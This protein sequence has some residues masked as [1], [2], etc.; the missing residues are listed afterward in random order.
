ML[1]LAGI[2]YAIGIGIVIVGGAIW[3]AYSSGGKNADARRDAAQGKANEKLQQK[4]DKIDGGSPSVDD[5]IDRLSK[6]DGGKP[7]P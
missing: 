5:A 7:K 2:L 6:R 1:T 3:K 4:F